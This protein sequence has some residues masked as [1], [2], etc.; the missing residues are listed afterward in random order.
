MAIWAMIVAI[1]DYP[2]M[3]AGLAQTLPDTNA[4][5]AKFR[6]WVMK[7][8]SVPAANIIACAAADCGWRS[9]GTTRTEIVNAFTELVTKAR[10]NADELYVFFSGHG[11]GLSEDPSDPAID[12]L[13]GSDF[14]Q[15]ST[16]GSACLRF[17]ETKERLRTALGPGK[18]FYFIDACRNPMNT[19]DIRPAILEMVWGRSRRGNAT[20]Y[21]FFST[22]PGDVANVNSGFG[23]ALLGGLKGSGRA[24]AWV[25]GKMYVTFESLSSYLQR[26][27][28]K[29][30]LDP[31][32]RGPA[33]GNIVELI[34]MPKSNCEL[35]VIGASAKDQFTLNVADVRMA[36]RDPVTFEGPRKT[37]PLPP[38]DYLLKLT[39]AAGKPVAQI[40]PPADSDGVDLYEDRTVRFSLQF[41]GPPPPQ[42]PLTAPSASLRILGVQG[43]EL[44]LR[45]IGTGSTKTLK[46]GADEL[47]TGLEPGFYKAHVKDGNYKLA[48]RGFKLSPGAT[49]NLDFTPRISKGAH[50][51]LSHK[52][53]IRGPRID[54][55]ET[56][57]DVA[58]WNLSLWLA[59]LGASRILAAPDT[60]SK[61]RSIQLESFTSA[62]PGKSLLYVLAGEL[63]SERV[64]ACDVGTS[65]KR[66]DMQPVAEADG[67]FE[68]K[69]ELEPGPQLV[70]YAPNEG[71]TST[72]LV[73]GLP[74]RTTLLTFAHHELQGRQ[75]Q[76]FIL[77]T[78]SL[79]Q[80]ISRQEWDYLQYAQ[81]LPLV[82]YMS[83]AQRLFA[84][85]S[86]IE[87][88][89]YEGSD[90][91]WF[92]LLYH[93]WLD[94]VMALIACYEVIR[95]GAAEQQK[96]FMQE[97]LA[98]MRKYFPGFADTEIIAMLLDEKFSP[99]QNPPLLMDGLIATGTKDALP[100]PADKLEFNSIWTM[101]K[102]ALLL[103]RP[104][105]MAVRKH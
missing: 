5:A 30:D 15:P 103:T 32:K 73:Y 90:R 91:Y 105:A 48:S 14:T 68:R 81:P 1:Q 8:K 23:N 88:H 29:N 61:L 97:V 11:I 22:A 40:D 9:T 63:G 21:V 13:I 98:N 78:H 4:T 101:W 85:Q 17:Q 39:T 2:N 33:D 35:E 18:H 19:N 38:E 76:Q 51:S 79:N 27:L 64:P 36:L 47:L 52:L 93:K 83:T 71:E 72:I 34:P 10:D 50:L 31:E 53:P 99:P 66:K 95:R 49:L 87:G 54:F 62:T 75:I 77:P 7:V 92:D 46:L 56:L 96:P 42:G 82:R 69:L 104:A 55:S 74:N 59:V 24:K 65:P 86:P 25:G 16:S 28:G 60:F 100:L 26:T 57:S 44:L 94:P 6:D 84:L 20:T 43:T 45:Q 70:T 58:D 67:L 89:T 80:Y 12:V 3:F 37:V 41:S 102:N